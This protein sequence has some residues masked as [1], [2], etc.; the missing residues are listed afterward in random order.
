MRN[1]RTLQTDHESQLRPLVGLTPEQAQL[2]W[3]CAVENPG[4]RKINARLELCF[5]VSPGMFEGQWHPIPTTSTIDAAH[6]FRVHLSAA[7]AS[8]AAV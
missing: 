6:D 8:S 2:A 1:L 4:G 3:T 5:L 7:M